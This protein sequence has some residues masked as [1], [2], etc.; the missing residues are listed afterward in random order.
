MSEL[1]R[2]LLSPEYRREGYSIEEI[3]E[4]GEHLLILR[5][6]G[7][8]IVRISQSGIAIATIAKIIAQEVSQN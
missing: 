8:E 7:K 4:F 1:S 3:Q 5:H 6:K 2:L